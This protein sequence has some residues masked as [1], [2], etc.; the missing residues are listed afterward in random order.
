MQA[1]RLS[2]IPRTHILKG[3]QGQQDS[4]VGKITATKPDLISLIPGPYVIK[5]KNLFAK[6][7]TSY[8]TMGLPPSKSLAQFY[9]LVIPELR[10]WGKKDTWEFQ[11]VTLVYMASYS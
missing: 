6:V 2:R 4:S 11:P 10:R 8:V 9:K 1:Q 5:G 7:V 3:R